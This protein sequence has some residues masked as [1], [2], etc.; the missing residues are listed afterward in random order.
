MQVWC[1]FVFFQHCASADICL[2]AA[3]TNKKT[4]QKFVGFSVCFLSAALSLHLD[5]PPAGLDVTEMTRSD[6]SHKQPCGLI[7][8]GH[9]A[10][11]SHR[12]EQLYHCGGTEW[13]FPPICLFACVWKPACVGVFVCVNIG[14]CA[15]RKWHLGISSALLWEPSVVHLA[16]THTKK[17]HTCTHAWDLYVVTHLWVDLWPIQIGSPSCS[18]RPASKGLTSFQT[19]PARV[20]NCRNQAQSL[21]HKRIVC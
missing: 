21:S 15:W 10:R 9:P 6:H 16:F 14:A 5:G 4:T 11:V 13:G 8:R 20:M 2:S 18:T 7:S 17:T 12:H 3:L 1:L 19:P